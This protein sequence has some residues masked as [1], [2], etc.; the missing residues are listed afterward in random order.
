MIDLP[1]GHEIHECL[2]LILYLDLL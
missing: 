1:Q 2:M